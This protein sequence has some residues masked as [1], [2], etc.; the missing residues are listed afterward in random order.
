MLPRR[1]ELLRFVGEERE[2]CSAV[3]DGQVAFREVRAIFRAQQ[4]NN[5]AGTVGQPKSETC[6]EEEMD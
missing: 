6:V 2:T 3:L 4:A 5:T 1:Q